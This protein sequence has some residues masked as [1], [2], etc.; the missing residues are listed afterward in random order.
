MRLYLTMV[1]ICISLKV[2]DIEHLL[3]CLL[4]ICVSS[5]LLILDLHINKRFPE[6]KV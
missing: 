1:L 6:P 4:A 5:G 2:S 3:L